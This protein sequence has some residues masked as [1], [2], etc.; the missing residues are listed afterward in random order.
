[1]YKNI[2]AMTSA[3]RS[4]IGSDWRDEFFIPNCIGSQHLVRYLDTSEATYWELNGVEATA[5]KIGN[6][7]GV[8]RGAKTW[9]YTLTGEG[10][11]VQVRAVW[12]EGGLLTPLK[13]HC[14]VIKVSP[15]TEDARRA[16]NAWLCSHSLL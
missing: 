9:V 4:R 2:T 5:R 12:C 14:R 11:S 15:D 8:P 10:F 7:T 3:A 16:Y 1:M 13:T 6:R